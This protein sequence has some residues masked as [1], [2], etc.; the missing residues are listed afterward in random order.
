MPIVQSLRIYMILH[1]GKMSSCYL[2]DWVWGEQSVDWSFRSLGSEKQYKWVISDSC[3]NFR[4]HLRDS[5]QLGQGNEEREG[6]RSR[7]VL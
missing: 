5:T 3:Q 7:I 2:S 6:L 1:L 4:L